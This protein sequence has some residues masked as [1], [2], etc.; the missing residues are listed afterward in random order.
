MKTCCSK[1]AWILVKHDSWAEDYLVFQSIWSYGVRSITEVTTELKWHLTNPS[2]LTDRPAKNHR[3]VSSTCQSVLTNHPLST[4]LYS[5][6]TSQF[7][8]GLIEFQAYN[9]RSQSWHA[10]RSTQS[11]TLSKLNWSATLCVPQIWW[12]SACQAPST[13]YGCLQNW[14]S[15]MAVRKHS[16]Y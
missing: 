1:G 9:T 3:G 13:E 2:F 7:L 4:L 14:L 8:N 5:V 6:A 11:P 12:I 15:N 10:K 16:R